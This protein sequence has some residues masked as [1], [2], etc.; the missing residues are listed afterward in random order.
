MWFAKFTTIAEK[1]FAGSGLL[2]ERICTF[3]TAGPSAKP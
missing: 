3:A 1:L 2:F